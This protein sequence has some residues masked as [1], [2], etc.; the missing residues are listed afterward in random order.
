MAGGRETAKENTGLKSKN[1]KPL[2]RKIRAKKILPILRQKVTV[3]EKKGYLILSG[4]Q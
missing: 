4:S 1:V 3:K 2:G